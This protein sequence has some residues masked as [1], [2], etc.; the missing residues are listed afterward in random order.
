MDY[1]GFKYVT[2]RRASYTILHEKTSNIAKNPWW[3]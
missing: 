2:R 3:V 1:G